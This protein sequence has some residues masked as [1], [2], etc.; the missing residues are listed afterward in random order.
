MKD[1]VEYLI[2]NNP[3]VYHYLEED[4]N[5][6]PEQIGEVMKK[7]AGEILREKLPDF[8][9]YAISKMLDANLE[10]S[11][12]AMEEIIEDYLKDE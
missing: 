6:S 2:A 4:L 8:P 5:L 11:I 10:V 1:P 12:P 7:Y 3:H 9:Q